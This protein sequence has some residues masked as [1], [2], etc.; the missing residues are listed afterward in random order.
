MN[1][2]RSLLLIAPLLCL[3]AALSAQTTPTNTSGTTATTPAPTD[4]RQ[5][6]QCR[7]YPVT[8]SLAQFRRICRTRA[9]WDRISTATNEE[10]LRDMGDRN[11]PDYTVGG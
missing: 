5:V 10:L 2:M 3:P 9:E 4:P 11:P 8:G 1:P 6:V 7:R